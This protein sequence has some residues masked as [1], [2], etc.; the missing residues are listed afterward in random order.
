MA[1]LESH[2]KEG[3]LELALRGE[4]NAANIAAI[5]EDWR[6]LDLGG[7]RAARI[8]ASTAASL[9]LAG[10]WQLDQ[11]LRQLE[12]SQVAVEHQGGLP[13]A[14][15]VVRGALQVDTA[16]RPAALREDTSDQPGGTD[17]PH[18]AGAAGRAAPRRLVHRPGDNDVP[19]GAGPLAAPA[20]DLR[21]PACLRHRDHRHPHRRA[22]R[23][24][25]QRDHRLPFRDASCATTGPTSTWWT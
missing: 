17:R 13:Q 16:A 5:R 9:D 24:P 14:V 20:T 23:L 2:R 18:G 1:F 4:W 22:D 19:G 15:E 11:F 21:R 10:A 8:D 25:D 7:V 12:S 3:T 6:A